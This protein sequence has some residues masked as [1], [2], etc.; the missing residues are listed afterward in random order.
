MKT[1][2]IMLLSSGCLLAADDVTVVM[3]VTTNAQ[4][5]NVTTVETVVPA[6][7]ETMPGIDPSWTRSVPA[8]SRSWRSR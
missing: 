6:G 5:G 4:T 2:S 1:F 7:A 8:S 3:N